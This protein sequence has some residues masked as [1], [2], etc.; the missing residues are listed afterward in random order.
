[1]AVDEDL[2]QQEHEQEH[3]GSDHLLEDDAF[4]LT[5]ITGGLMRDSEV[6]VPEWADGDIDHLPDISENS[7]GDDELSIDSDDD[8]L[9][10]IG[11][12]AGKGCHTVEPI[13]IY[14]REMGAMPLLSHEEE[15][16]LARIMEKGLSRI[17]L[18]VLST[19]LAIP[20]LQSLVKELQAGRVKITQIL[21]GLSDDQIDVLVQV[22]DEFIRRVAQATDLEQKREALRQ[23]FLGCAEGT[24]DDGE[25]YQQILALG[26]EIAETFQDRLICSRCINGI[27]ASLEE[28]ANRFRIVRAQVMQEYTLA[29]V[30]Q[31]ALEVSPLEIEKKIGR[32]LREGLGF[33]YRALQAILH[34]IEL[35]REIVNDAKEALVRAN[36]R[37]VV[38]V[39]KK[40]VNRGLHFP[41]LVQE[42][43][44]G[45]IK[46]VEK[47]DYHRGYKFSTYATWWIR[48]SITRG[49]ADQGRTIRLPVH[50]IETINR[51]LRVTRDFVRQENREPTP[52]EMAEQLGID[53]LK[54]RAA[55][56]T[57]KDAISLDMPVGTDEESFLSDF[58]E[59]CNAIGPDQSC[60]VDSLK[61]CLRR[62]MAT[63]STREV[64]VL[65][66]RYGI[67]V[68][69][70]HTLEEVGKCFAV[71]RERIRQIEAQAIQKL[72]HPSRLEE[73]RVFVKD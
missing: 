5:E 37:L 54:V 43:N 7:E 45:L 69:C 8:D 40:F 36:L 3:A 17:Q 25:I 47:F 68:S 16:E 52:E 61:E 29:M 21:K 72:Q 26:T 46:A 19:P 49:I 60:M 23:L 53:V 71:T 12:P 44:I 34:E 24:E 51:L 30:E 48:Q 50:M 59:D 31:V 63:L 27:A 62:V 66:L 33:G 11:E 6:I 10:S 2:D 70:D 65:Q 18:A 15:F 32:V 55:L 9:G 64:K 42:G 4:D 13:S 56:K 20:A 1:M 58:I 35:A 67:D 28:L 57:A 38:S 73:L 39:A 41:D 14:L 22:Q